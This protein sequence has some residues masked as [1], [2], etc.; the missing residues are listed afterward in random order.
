MFYSAFTA[1]KRDS[2]F[3]TKDVK[4]VVF[5]TRGYTKINGVSFLPKMVYTE[6]RGGLIFAQYKSI[7]IYKIYKINILVAGMI[8]EVWGV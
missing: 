4:R 5:I 7:N 2:R 8:E 1:V 6:V 3:L